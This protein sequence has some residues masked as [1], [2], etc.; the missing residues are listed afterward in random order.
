MWCRPTKHE[1]GNALDMTKFASRRE[2]GR[3]V[4][5]RLEE[6]QPH[7]AVNRR[8]WWRNGSGV[9]VVVEGTCQRDEGGSR[10]KQPQRATNE[11]TTR[12][13]AKALFP[14]QLTVQRGTWPQ[15]AA[16]A[17]LVALGQESNWMWKSAAGFWWVL[18]GSGGPTS[19]FIVPKFSR[20]ALAGGTSSGI[21]RA[22]NKFSNPFFYA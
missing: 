6:F 21:Q 3:R 15:L 2:G 22:K 4:E 7:S 11:N 18:V 10:L 5:L 19:C 16:A 13:D 14:F 17:V 20:Q 8:W 12:K 9:V 1:G